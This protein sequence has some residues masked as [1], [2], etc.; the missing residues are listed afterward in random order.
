MQYMA[1]RRLVGVVGMAM[2]IALLVGEKILQPGPLPGSISAYYYTDM[3]RVLV[4]C[5]CAI[6]CFLAVYR[7][8]DRDYIPIRIAAVCAVGVAW[9]PTGAGVV[10]VLHGIFAAGMFLCLAYICLFLFTR[11]EERYPKRR[12]RER[13]TVYSVC[14]YA[15]VTCLILVGPA[16]WIHALGPLHPVFW[17]ETAAIE[18]FGVSWLV[19]GQAILPDN[20]R[21]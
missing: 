14:G 15:I 4:G 18:S 9:F 2:P 16:L 20:G 3:G 7:G 8:Y 5:L 10:G 6:S 1:L 11:S 13:N 17:L 12:K 21:L 19:K